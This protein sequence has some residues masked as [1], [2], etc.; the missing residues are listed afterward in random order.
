MKKII[1]TVLC[2]TLIITGA[3]V[4]GKF[5][6]PVE[7]STTDEITSQ[8]ISD[9]T[10]ETPDVARDV[11]LPYYKGKSFNPFKTKSPT[12][13]SI[14]TLLYDSLFVMNEDW[15]ST[16][17]IAKEFHNDGK[18]VTVKLVD[19]AVFS[20]G[21]SLTAYDVVYS[22]KLAKKCDAYKGR[23]SNFA[24]A[25][26]GSDSVTF[27][28]N[29]PDIYAQQCLTFPLVQNGTGTAS[30]PIGSG[31]YVLRSI[32][33][34]YVL[35]ANADNT[36]GESLKIKT[37]G[38]VPITSESKEIYRVQTGELSYYYNDMDTGTFTKLTA[39]VIPV[40]TNNLIYLI[41]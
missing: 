29:Q 20:N 2:L 27:T 17:L 34:Q 18:K 11:Y 21:A 7:P 25:T 32:N 1:I 36:R 37:L 19:G 41:S 24:G 9:E 26:A 39:S 40:Q 14:S 13:L 3:I 4:T 6:K 31:R 30:L 28:L 16:M 10:E 12:N 15:S 8:V 35:S 23:L 22:F 38:L 5:I 33:G